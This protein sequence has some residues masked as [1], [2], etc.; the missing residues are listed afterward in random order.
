MRI[1]GYEDKF[2]Y[3]NLRQMRALRARWRAKPAHVSRICYKN[4]FIK[5]EDQRIWGS[6]DLRILGKGIWFGD[7]Q[8]IHFCFGRSKM[9]FHLYGFL[10]NCSTFFMDF[11]FCIFFVDFETFLFVFDTKKNGIMIS[12]HDLWSC[13]L[14]GHYR[15]RFAPPRHADLLQKNIFIKSEDL[16]ILWK[17]NWFG[18]P[19][20][21]HFCFGRSKMGFQI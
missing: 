1:W 6:E 9:G 7:P 15:R 2:F 4:I 5:S 12:E 14:R 18:D 19:Q 8:K 21:I 10:K 16:R 13:P 11:D 3:K 20:K 17:G